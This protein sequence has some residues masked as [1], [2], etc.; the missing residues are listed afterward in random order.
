MVHRMKTEKGLLNV[1]FSFASIAVLILVLAIIGLIPRGYINASEISDDAVLEM[2][3]MINCDMDFLYIVQNDDFCIGR[4]NRNE[5]I[6]IPD[7]CKKSVVVE[8]HSYNE[9]GKNGWFIRL[10]RAMDLEM[11]EDGKYITDLP[12]GNV[13][14]TC[15]ELYFDLEALPVKDTSVENQR[16][17][18]DFYMNDIYGQP[19]ELIITKDLFPRDGLDGSTRGMVT[20]LAWKNTGQ[21]ETTIYA[22]VWNEWDSVYVMEGLTDKAGTAYFDGYIL[23]DAS[24]VSLVVPKK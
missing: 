5:K 18:A 6:I 21:C 22:V 12:L 16:Q 9:S 1:I 3:Q 23:R 4:I 20:K 10:Y 8:S 17:L 7:E 14:V 2:N 13:K 15:D 24:T 19:A 11:D